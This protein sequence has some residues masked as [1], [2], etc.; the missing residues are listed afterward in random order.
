MGR[1]VLEPEIFAVL[2]RQEPGAGGEIQLTDALHTLSMVQEVYAYNFH[3]IRYDIGDK[4]GFIKA[5]VDFALK[6]SDLRD[7][8]FRYIQGL[9]EREL[10]LHGR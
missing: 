10:I 2:E 5:T 1:Y 3:G 7:D 8:V 6:R 4:L 9:M